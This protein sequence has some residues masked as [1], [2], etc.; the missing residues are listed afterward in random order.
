MKMMI[1]IVIHM[2]RLNAELVCCLGLFP[3]AT[4]LYIAMAT[5]NRTVVPPRFFRIAPWTQH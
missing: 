3:C 1:Q 4:S 5:A 2:L